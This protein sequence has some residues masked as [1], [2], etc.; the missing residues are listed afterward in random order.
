MTRYLFDYSAL[1]YLRQV[2]RKRHGRQ[3]C[4]VYRASRH[5]RL[6]VLPLCLLAGF[7]HAATPRFTGAA[8][9]QL[10][11]PTSANGRFT[12]N[13]QMQPGT[14]VSAN[15]RFALQAKLQPD[16]KSLLGICGGAEDIFRNGFE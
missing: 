2:S 15:G 8:Q 11:D 14:A 4:F 16:Q 12:L 1:R 6:V 5:L 7:A 10:A 9:L 3:D 13:A